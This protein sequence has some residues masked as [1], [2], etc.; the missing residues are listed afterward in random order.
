MFTENEKIEL[1]KS[2]KEKFTMKSTWLPLI[3]CLWIC[4]HNL[5]AF[6]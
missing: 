4:C 1:R 2:F 3:F 6:K 5:A